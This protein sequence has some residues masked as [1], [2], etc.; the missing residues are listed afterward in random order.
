M[1]IAESFEVAFGRETVWNIFLDPVE[2]ASCVPGVRDIQLI[3]PTH[4]DAEMVVKVPFLALHFAVHGELRESIENSRLVVDL[5][6]ESTSFAGAFRA[7]LSVCLDDGPG[8]GS[9]IAYEIDMH[10]TGRLASLGEALMRS[11]ASNMGKAF[12]ENIKARL[13]AA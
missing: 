8:G 5:D 4:Y 2:L 3:D 6:G 10:M 1:R 9:V 7:E 13:A 12:A 11:T